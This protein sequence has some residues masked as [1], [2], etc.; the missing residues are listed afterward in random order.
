MLVASAILGRVRQNDVA[1][2][3]GATSSPPARDRRRDRAGGA[4][5]AGRHHR[6]AGAGASLGITI[7]EPGETDPRPVMARADRSPPGQA[8]RQADLQVVG[9]TRRFI[10]SDQNRRELEVLHRQAVELP[11]TLTVTGVTDLPAEHLVL[12]T[13]RAGECTISSWDA[14]VA[15]EL[16]SCPSTSSAAASTRISE[17]NC[18]RWTTGRT[19]APCWPK[20]PPTASTAATTRPGTSVCATSWTSGAGRPGSRCHWRSRRARWA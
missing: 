7:A 10:Q 3:L 20:V 19:A 9:V 13:R 1:G 11:L 14:R 4:P 5:G 17:A 8:R 12:A 16:R 6:Q 2:R 15:T 18:S